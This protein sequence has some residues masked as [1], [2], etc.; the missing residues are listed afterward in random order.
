MPLQTTERPAVLTREVAVR[1]VDISRSGCL[2]ETNRRFEVGAVGALRLQFG[3]G[4]YGDDV[5]VVR[6]QKVEGGSVYRVGVRFLA[7][8]PRHEH[9]IRHAV[10]EYVT[11][12]DESETTWVM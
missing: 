6:C 9:S 10:S 4:E 12:L 3:T 5:Q 1:I 7:T 8:T 2:I 11:E